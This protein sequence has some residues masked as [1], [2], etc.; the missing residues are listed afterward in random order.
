MFDAP[1]G[2]VCA[3]LLPPVMATNVAAL[4]ARDAAHPALARYDEVARILTGTPAAT[5]ADGVAWV[6]ALC[7]ELRLTGLAA[8]GLTPAHFDAVIAKAA[9]ASSMK[10]N[11][12][13]LTGEEMA[14][15]LRRA[16]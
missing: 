7:A 11:P 13:V 14:E 12:I 9:G 6:A 4:A 10:G 8:F 3:A 15:I 5:A 2:A 1:H 16:L